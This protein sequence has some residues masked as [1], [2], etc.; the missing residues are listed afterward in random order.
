MVKIIFGV[1]KKCKQLLPKEMKVSN[2]KVFQIDEPVE[3][4]IP[5]NTP[6]IDIATISSRLDA[7]ITSVEMPLFSP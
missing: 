2:N 4:I 7:A 1:P 6:N 3:K 5:K